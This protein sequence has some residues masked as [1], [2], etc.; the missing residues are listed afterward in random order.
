MGM[1]DDILPKASVKANRIHPK[2]IQHLKNVLSVK[3]MWCTWNQGIR[4]QNERNASGDSAGMCFYHVQDVWS[5]FP[6]F[7]QTYPF[8]LKTH[9]FVFPAPQ[10]FQSKHIPRT[11]SERILLLGIC[12]GRFASMFFVHVLLI[13]SSNA[14]CFVLCLAEVFRCDVPNCDE[15]FSSPKSL[16][17]HK[18]K[19]GT[20]Y[21][22]CW[23]TP[24]TES[25]N[26][27]AC[28]SYV[29]SESVIHCFTFLR[30]FVTL[31]GGGHK[32]CDNIL[33]KQIRI[34]IPKFPTTQ[35]FTSRMH[36]ET[37]WLIVSIWNR[38]SISRKLL[39][40]TSLI[41]GSQIQTQHNTFGQNSSYACF[42]E[43]DSKLLTS[44]FLDC[45][46]GHVANAK[47]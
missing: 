43:R 45:F 29:F 38:E 15:I 47:P 34:I 32:K 5:R 9:P 14:M 41:P 23:Y 1:R 18:L 24:I 4:I 13:P 39:C 10:W 17:S 11:N 19:H 46:G 31:G 40:E 22:W 20:A 21:R 16:A 2:L 42:G 25:L 26:V 37:C 35:H 36:T 27:L 7:G 28:R 6:V 8:I 30:S 12:S 44:F 33:S 3:E